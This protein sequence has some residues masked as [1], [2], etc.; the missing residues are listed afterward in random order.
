MRPSGQVLRRVRL[1]PF[2][3]SIAKSVENPKSEC[4]RNV[5]KTFPKMDVG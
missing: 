3:P 1:S 4:S 5:S 2:V